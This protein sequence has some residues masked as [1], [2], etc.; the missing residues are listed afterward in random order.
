MIGGKD[1]VVQ[2]SG[3]AELAEHLLKLLRD[4]WPEMIVEDADTGEIIEMTIPHLNLVPREFFVYQ[5]LEMKDLWDEEG[6]CVSNK[7]TMVHVLLQD[8]SITIVVD[9][10]STKMNQNM[11]GAIQSLARELYLVRQE[12]AV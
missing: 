3:P 5:N 12:F 11:L 6:A 2:T 10:T 9:D 7:N 1:I 8:D 4:D